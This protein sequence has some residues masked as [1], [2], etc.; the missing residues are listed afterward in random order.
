MNECKIFFKKGNQNTGSIKF[1]FMPK[2]TKFYITISR[3]MST[4]SFTIAYY[5]YLLLQYC[6]FLHILIPALIYHMIRKILEGFP[7]EGRFTGQSEG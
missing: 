7:E 3:E 1:S 6:R 4:V 2:V 5:L